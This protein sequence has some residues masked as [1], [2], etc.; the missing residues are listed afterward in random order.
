[1]KTF[2]RLAAVLA[3]VL[4]LAL[5]IGQARKTVTLVIDGSARTLVTFALTTSM[6]LDQQGIALAPADEL[7]PGLDEWLSNGGTV[8]IDRAASI[9]ILADGQAHHLLTTGRIPADLLALAGVSL[10][11]GDRLLSGGSEISPAGPLPLAPA[12]ALYV[13]RAVTVHLQDGADLSTFTTTA[14][15]VGQAL[16]ENG[17]R[18]YSADRLTPPASARLTGPEMDVSL[19]RSRELTIQ[20]SGQE[21]RLR[22]AAA[23]VGEALAEVGF[24]LQGLDYSI[25]EAS[26]PLPTDGWIKI[27]R[28]SESVATEQTPLPFETEYQP[29]ADLEIDNQTIIRT[30]EY[31]YTAQRVRV[32]YEDGVEVSR[33]VEDQWIAAEPLNRIVG[34]G[35]N[36][37]MHSLDTPDGTIYYWRALTMWITSY[38]DSVGKITATGQRVRKGLVGVNP[39]YIPYGTMMYVPGYGYAEAADTGNIGPRW[40]DLGYPLADYVPWHQYSTVYF[41]WPPPPPEQILWIYPP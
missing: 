34:Y 28:V 41:I 25:P 38:N 17:A 3:A 36:L 12:H 16:W 30:G 10:Y 14:A 24:A 29:V 39:R 11:P 23:T 20:E 4:A 19:T 9:L 1:M 22:S 13:D 18:V 7:S 31:G 37:V 15:T 27:V 35:T 26:D 32:R 8:Q 2:L 21:I 6:L 33:T 5:V 40:I